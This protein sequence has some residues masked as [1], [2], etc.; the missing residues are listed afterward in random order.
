MLDDNGDN[1]LELSYEAVGYPDDNAYYLYGYINGTSYDYDDT[2]VPEEYKFVNG[3]LTINIYESSYVFIK[4]NYGRKYYMKDWD[5]A[6]T[7]ADFLEE[8]VVGEGGAY[9]YIPFDSEVTFTLTEN[10]DG[11]LRLSYTIDQELW[12]SVP[13]QY[14]HF[15]HNRR[16]YLDARGKRDSDAFGQR[17]NRQRNVAVCRKD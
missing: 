13:A 16:L 6:A 9:M 5:E 4:T 14:P 17:K 11:S 7:E 15:R 1:T 8:K 10:N 12:S 3:K 2:E